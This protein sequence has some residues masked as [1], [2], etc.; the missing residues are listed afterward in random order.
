[1]MNK[2][3]GLDEQK[4]GLSVVF[5]Q[6]RSGNEVCNLA[7]HVLEIKICRHNLCPVPTMLIVGISLLGINLSKTLFIPYSVFKSVVK[8]L[9]LWLSIQRL[10]PGS[11]S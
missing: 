8:N 4:T 10:C 11:V 3:P 5:L 1:M 7:L 9:N 6:P 2:M